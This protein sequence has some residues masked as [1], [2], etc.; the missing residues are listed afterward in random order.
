MKIR[1]AIRNLLAIPSSPPVLDDNE[2]SK[3]GDRTFNISLDARL[4]SSSKSNTA[5]GVTSP[6]ELQV[7]PVVADVDPDWDVREIIDKEDLNGVSYYLVDWHPT[8]LPSHSLGHI[9]ELVDKFEARIRA[10]R[11]VSNKRG[12]LG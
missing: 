12:R 1:K 4:T 11:R 9:K 3:G 8:L 7:C 10:Q 6:A 5:S 2:N